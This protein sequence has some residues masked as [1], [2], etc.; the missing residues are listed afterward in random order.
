M[1]YSRRGRR[2]QH[3]SKVAEFEAALAASKH[4]APGSRSATPPRA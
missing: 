4:F 3:G 2:R 1:A